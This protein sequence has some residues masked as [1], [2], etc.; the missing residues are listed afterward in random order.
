MNR[1]AYFLELFAIALVGILVACKAFAYEITFLRKV[2]AAACFAFFYTIPV[3]F[4]LLQHGVPAVGLYV[5][6]MDDRYDR[7]SVRNVF[8][9]TY[10]FAVSATLALFYIHR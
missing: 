3:P 4:L 5:C 8:A 6:L 1:A 10:V 2:C 9:A 7:R